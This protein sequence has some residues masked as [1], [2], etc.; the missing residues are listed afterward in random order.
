MIRALALCVFLAGCA[1]GSLLT[2][3]GERVDAPQGY[4]KLCREHPDFEGC[5]P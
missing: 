1:S 3:S 2:G 4:V 5:K